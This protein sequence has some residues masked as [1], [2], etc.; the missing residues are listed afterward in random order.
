MTSGRPGGKPDS[1]KPEVE[2]P[3]GKPE[4]GKPEGG[5]MTLRSVF[6]RVIINLPLLTVK[7][8]VCLRD[9]SFILTW[10]SQIK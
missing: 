9:F 6:L 2:K 8:I 7:F 1:D 5:K 3:N 10:I 4:G